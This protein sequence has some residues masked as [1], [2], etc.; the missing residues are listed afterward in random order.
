MESSSQSEPPP[1]S[2]LPWPGQVVGTII[3]L[4]TLAIPLFAIAYFASQTLEPWQT[5]AYPVLRSTR[6]EMD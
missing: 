4:L 1:K 5:P 6:E 3:A 2:T